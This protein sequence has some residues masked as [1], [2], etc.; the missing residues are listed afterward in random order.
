[1]RIRVFL[2]ILVAIFCTPPAFAHTELSSQADVQSFINMMVKKYHFNRADLI[3]TLN[4]V[5][6]R[7]SSLKRTAAPAEEEPW[8]AYR[9]VFITESRIREGVAFWQKY[10][11]ALERAEQ[12]Y[13]VPASIIVATIGVETKYGQNTG[14]YRVIDALATLAFSNSKR[15]PFFRNELKELFLLAR[16]QHVDPL[17]IKGSYAGAIGQPQFMPSSYRYYA[18]DFSGD[19]KIDLS[20]NEVD[21]IGSIANYY[22]LHGWDPQQPIVVHAHHIPILSRW[23]PDDKVPPHQNTTLI[24]LQD[25]FGKEY[26][27]GFHNF[28]V[29]KRY[30]P[31]NLYAMAVYQLSY[32][33]DTAKGG[34]A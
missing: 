19:G 26:W 7:Q 31:S 16:D 22:K 9:N 32:Y 20:H 14:D 18:V 13:G 24:T 27:L 8:Y 11:D 34:T 4:A 1:M 21:I 5:R 3:H 10:H 28:Q 30:N 6:I 29:I 15:A 23:V 17:K 2:I 12:I 33:I 25:Y